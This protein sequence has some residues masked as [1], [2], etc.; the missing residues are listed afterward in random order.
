MD[1]GF[2]R[3]SWRISSDIH[4]NFPY[5]QSDRFKVSRTSPARDR[6]SNQ[7]IFKCYRC[8][9]FGHLIKQCKSER[10]TYKSV[11]N[12]RRDQIRLQDFIQKKLCSNFPF[13][14]LDD[15]EFRKATSRYQCG[16]RL[17]I[18][19]LK[20]EIAY[21][22]ELN[23]TEDIDNQIKQI[24]RE[25][26]DV[27]EQLKITEDEYDELAKE[28]TA[29]KE[30]STYGILIED[31]NELVEENIKLC[32]DKKQYGR[33]IQDLTNQLEEQKSI[34]RSLE[35]QTAAKIQELQREI[36]DYRQER[37]NIDYQVTLNEELKEWMKLCHE[38]CDR[39]KH[40]KSEIERLES[41]NSETSKI[42]QFP[43]NGAQRRHVPH[44]RGNRNSR[45][46][47][48]GRAYRRGNV[49]QN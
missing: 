24:K 31:W 6:R 44:Q 42:Y 3:W 13:F 25:N 37:E 12:I 19:N 2:P 35:Q 4:N 29:Y 48:P 30:Q 26:S 18:E 5:Q 14:E 22:N 34:V 21:L 33:V 16:P 27:K 8:G 46:A 47:G 20:R 23:E 38:Q 11:K 28:F 40:Y 39:I 45:R 15:S 7:N 10:K 49:N 1:S 32:K 43:H 36:S 41:S 17:E 9:Q